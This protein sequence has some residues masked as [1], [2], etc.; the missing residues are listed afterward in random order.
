M[1]ILSSFKSRYI[2]E[3]KSEWYQDYLKDIED[4]KKKFGKLWKYRSTPT[5]RNYL[6][7]LIMKMRRSWPE[8]LS[9]IINNCL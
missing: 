9:H 5:T 2:H 1:K 7:S 8:Y 3:N 4:C 6:K